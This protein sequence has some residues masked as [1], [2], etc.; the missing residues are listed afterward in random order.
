MFYL[1]PFGVTE[2]LTQPSNVVF[3]TSI[4]IVFFTSCKVNYS[5]P[6]QT[7]FKKINIQK[8]SFMKLV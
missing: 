8:T 1:S 7:D 2:I 6:Q 4:E 5:L 3:F